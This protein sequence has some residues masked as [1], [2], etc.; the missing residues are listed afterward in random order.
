MNFLTL[1]HTLSPLTGASLLHTA[2]DLFGW[3]VVDWFI[4]SEEGMF[5]YIVCEVMVMLV[6]KLKIMIIFT[7]RISPWCW[8]KSATLSRTA[9]KY[10]RT[11]V[12]DRFVASEVVLVFYRRRITS[13]K[14]ATSF[15][16][17]N[18]RF[19]MNEVRSLVNTRHVRTFRDTTKG[20]INVSEWSR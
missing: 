20:I 5:S 8:F 16:V 19:W 11:D 4:A 18:V 10:F 13:S 1:E 15:S 3:G 2:E 14:L 7:Q 12:E 17:R 6:R 9:E